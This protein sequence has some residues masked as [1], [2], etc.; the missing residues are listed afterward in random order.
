MTLV[1]VI[2]NRKG[3]MTAIA[4]SIKRELLREYRLWGFKIV[5]MNEEIAIRDNL[6]VGEVV[7]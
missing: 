7:S 3:K 4:E 2:K 5:V 6:V 1:L